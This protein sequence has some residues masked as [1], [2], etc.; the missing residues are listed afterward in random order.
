MQSRHR[1]QENVVSHQIC[2][3]S[4]NMLQCS[5]YLKY[6]SAFHYPLIP[7]EKVIRNGTGEQLVLFFFFEL[8]FSMLS[9]L[10]GDIFNKEGKYKLYRAFLAEEQFLYCVPFNVVIFNT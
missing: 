3:D 7:V 2:E 5:N 8:F 4:S 6:T 9:E 10:T 1:I